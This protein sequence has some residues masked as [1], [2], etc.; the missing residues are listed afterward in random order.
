MKNLK[1]QF[2]LS[3][4]LP[5]IIT[6]PLIGVALSYAMETSFILKD[7]KKT[8][9][10]QAQLIK[11]YAEGNPDIW[12]DHESAN[13]LIQEIRPQLVSGIVLFDQ[14]WQWI[15]SSDNKPITLDLNSDFS[16]L[17]SQLQQKSFEPFM[18][19]NPYQPFKKSGDIIEMM[20]PVSNDKDELLGVIRLNLP[21]NYF[22]N[23]LKQ[24]STRIVIILICGILLGIII[25]LFNAIRLE[26]QLNR[27]TNAIYD[28]SGGS[29]N[30]PLPETGPA[31]IRKL[32][33]AFNKL[34][35]KLETSEQTRTKLIS[36]LTHELGRPLGALAS[37]VDS[38]NL[39]AIQ[40]ENLTKDLTSGMK[41]EIKR[42]EL[43][44]GDLSILRSESDPLNQYFM[45]PVPLAEWLMNFSTYWTK[46]A[47][48]NQ[49]N[50]IHEIPD[51]LPTV[52]ID[53]NRFHQAVGN[54][55][56]NA[57][58]YSSKG[59][60]VILSASAKPE[61]IQISVQDFGPGISQDDLPHIFEP[62]YRGSEK[63]R[64]IQ[65]MGLGLNIAQEIVEAHHGT[66][67]VE[68]IK[69]KGSTFTI[70]LPLQSV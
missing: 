27:T 23:Q 37:A 59:G 45:K 8:I 10:Y 19:V 70:H 42:L 68:S 65:G 13:N 64:F 7:M 35:Q 36:Y 41:M 28:L 66:I 1:L 31:E 67:S 33:A 9:E 60:D 49:V 5:V 62:F 17:V 6:I 63:K 12:K 46:Y 20:V 21:I 40:D 58:K 38:L 14:T 39:G 26:E 3:H 69:G 25:G 61:E 15:A 18:K 55:L 54:I 57:I 16:L 4:I 50:L 56:S 44:V 2:I 43:L 52:L 11:G 47:Q 30:K 48:N 29:K 32:S 53:E 22:E 34:S 24:T 51:Q